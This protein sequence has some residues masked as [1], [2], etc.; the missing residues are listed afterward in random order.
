MTKEE[1]INELIATKCD[2]R[3]HRN[4]LY[5]LVE[6]GKHNVRELLE[7]SFEKK[8]YLSFRAGRVLEFICKKSLD[9]IVPHLDYF[10]QNISMVAHHST[11]REMAKICEL[12][13]INY[14]KKETSL[15]KSCITQKQ[16]DMIVEAC[17]DWM[18][19]D[20]K[21][22]IHAYSMQILFILGKENNWIHTELKQILVDNIA[23]GSKGYVVRAKK[24]LQAIG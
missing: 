23:F 24:I 22:A 1:I 11:R 17:F 6:N 16:K 2:P 12:I 15:L 9:P 8:D 10:T 5:R 13:A 21:V 14:N 20:E 18:I 7:L 4:R 19:S 3:N